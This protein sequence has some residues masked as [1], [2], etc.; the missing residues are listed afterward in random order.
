M[1]V[2]NEQV[3]LAMGYTQSATSEWW[4]LL[5]NRGWGAAL[6][7]F[8]GKPKR[9]AEVKAEMIRRGWPFAVHWGTTVG[10]SAYAWGIWHTGDTEAEAV[11]K[12][13]VAAN[14]EQEKGK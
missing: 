2:T 10:W 1:T 3:A 5:P 6:P 4:K 8:L 7:D 14:A 13:F 9:L 11:C 12:A